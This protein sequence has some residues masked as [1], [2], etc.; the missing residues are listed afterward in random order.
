MKQY[1]ELYKSLRPVVL[2]EVN[3]RMEKAIM[4]HKSGRLTK[5][6]SHDIMVEIVSIASLLTTIEN[7]NDDSSEPIPQPK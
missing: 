7:L 3:D 4:L 1:N 6:K 5:R 2:D